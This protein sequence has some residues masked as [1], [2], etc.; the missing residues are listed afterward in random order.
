[1]IQKITR[2]EESFT[3]A[4]LSVMRTM[5]NNPALTKADIVTAWENNEIVRI[6]DAG[7]YKY[8]YEDFAKFEDG[9]DKEL[10]NKMDFDTFLNEFKKG[11]GKSGCV[12]V[13]R[14]FELSNGIWY[15]NEYVA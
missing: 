10:R 7:D 2:S 11:Y 6:A 3:D 8:A 1:M 13:A 12:Q 9:F 4:D 14:L 15:D 5:F